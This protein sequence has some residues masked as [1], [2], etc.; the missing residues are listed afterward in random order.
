MSSFQPQSAN[1]GIPSE[2]G[3][4]T[5]NAAM[6][7]GFSVPAMSQTS[8]ASRTLW[9]VPYSRRLRQDP[10][11]R[12]LTCVTRMGELEPWMDENFIKQIFTTVAGEAVNVKVIRDRNS[13]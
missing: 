3:N 5:K 7:N 6:D 12:F 8:E 4:G 13:G 2:A 10:R 1:G 9:S 11:R